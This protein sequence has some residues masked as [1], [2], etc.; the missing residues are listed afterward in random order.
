LIDILLEGLHEELLGF[1][2]HD[3]DLAGDPLVHL[4]LPLD[5][6]FALDLLGDLADLGFCANLVMWLI[7]FLL[8]ILSRIS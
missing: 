4:L 5:G 3:V 2:A 7:Y 1:S 6:V 8:S